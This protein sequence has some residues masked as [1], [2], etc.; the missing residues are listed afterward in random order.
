MSEK[1]KNII[2]CLCDQLRASEVGC[3][4]NDIIQTPNM[5][6]L[7]ASGMR[8]QYG[9][10]NDPLCMPARSTVVSGQYARTCSGQLNNTS[11]LF[12]GGWMMPPY[13]EEG[14]P[15]LPDKTLP[16][17][18]RDEG[19]YN[20]AIGKWH[21][22]TWPHEIGFDEYVIPRTQHCHLGQHYTANGGAEFVP[23]GYSLEFE[24]D[25]VGSFLQG[26]DEQPFFLFFNISPPHTPFFDIPNEYRTMYDPR[27]MP[28]RDNCFIDGVMAGNE[29]VFRTYLFENKHYFYKLPHTKDMP[30]DFDLRDLYTQYYGATSWVDSAV[31]RLMGML[32]ENGLDEDTI[33]LFTADHGDNLGSHHRW[34]KTLMYQESSSVPCIYHVPGVTNGK[35]ADT[36]MVSHVDIMP[37]MLDLIGAEAPP[38][39]QGRSVAPVIRGEV[40]VL[41][42][43]YVFIE[44]EIQAVGVRTPQYTF[45]KRFD[46]ATRQ[47]SRDKMRLYDIKAD[48]FEMTNL[49]DSEKEHPAIGEWEGILDDWHENTPWMEREQHIETH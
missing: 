11:V 31:G 17:C 36:Q 33:V 5:D 49:A 27:E 34:N 25:T 35:V 4:G 23:P 20:A 42:N 45:A 3:Y 41:L 15:H 28:I 29:N 47:T 39:V 12:P 19:Y 46:R 22:H 8:F 1:K 2:V 16:E 38:H 44:S 18:L 24:L 48:P 43:N 32:Q 30:E 40:D 26:R 10:T 21:I 9:V 6:A 37:T 7:A 13:P 14:R